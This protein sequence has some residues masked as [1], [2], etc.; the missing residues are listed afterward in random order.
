[1]RRS[2]APP[3]RKIGV[4]EE[5]MAEAESWVRVGSVADVE[6]G[7]V[8]AAEASGR[9]LAVY[10]LPGGEICATDNTCTHAFALLS[11]GWFEDCVI[12]CPLHA[13]RFDVRTGKGLGAPIEE[14]L[15]T[16]EVRVDGD[17]IFVLLAG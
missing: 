10:H 17:D 11:E 13:G 12:E 14:D 2:P 15:Q 1:M 16:Y 9:S 8:M 4:K 7:T 6:V 3:F 5:I